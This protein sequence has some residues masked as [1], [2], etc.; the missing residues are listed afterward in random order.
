[1]RGHGLLYVRHKETVDIPAWDSKGIGS[2]KIHFLPCDKVAT[3]SACYTPFN[4]EY[5]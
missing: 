4:P 2:L 5:P 3:S 1:M